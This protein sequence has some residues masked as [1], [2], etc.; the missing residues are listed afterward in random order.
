MPDPFWQQPFRMLQ[1]NLREIDAAG[2]DVAALLDVI[3]DY[4]GDAILANAGGIVAWYPTRLPFHRKNK[5]LDFDF[6]G[7]VIDEAHARGMKVMLRM[8]VSK[9]H[10]DQYEAHPDWFIHD[11]EGRPVREWS[12]LATC[13]NGP[14]WQKHNFELVDELL[15]GYAPDALFYNHYRYGECWCDR[16]RDAFRRAAGRELPDREDWDDPGWRAYVRFRYQAVEEYSRRLVDFVQQR[17]PDTAVS[18]PIFVTLDE[19]ERLCRSG[20]SAQGMLVPDLLA[21]EAFN[22]LGRPFPQ[23]IYLG[24]EE[25]RISRS[26]GKPLF[27]GITY[28][29]VFASRRSGQPAAQ[30]AHDIIQVAAHGG[31]PALAVSGTF[32]QDDR[33]ALPAA[34]EAYRFL[35]ANHAC[36]EEMRPLGRTLLVYSQKTMDFYGRGQSRERAL[37]EYRGFYEALVHHHLLFDVAHDGT[38]ASMDLARYRTILLPNVACLSADEASLLDQFVADG[39]NLIAS[40]E[41]GMYDDEGQQTGRFALASLRLR[42][43]E[44]RDLVGSYLLVGNEKGLLRSFADV[45]LIALNGPFLAVEPDRPAGGAAP[46]SSHDT[47]RAE[48][49]AGVRL[50]ERRR[51]RLWPLRDALRPRDRDLPSL[52]AWA[53][54]TTSRACPSRRCCSPTCWTARTAPA[55]S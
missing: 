14:Y 22:A 19:P 6:V 3:R 5:H 21:T 30:L 33:K 39:G 27:V 51:G 2:L 54:P 37:F 52:A 16:C 7:Q 41:T 32:E 4:G 29:E 25:S 35:A 10:D 20:W 34:R 13:F 55:R 50:L 44:R 8:D 47:R 46:R 12:M 49:H 43:R 1:P 17:R 53:G 26:M 48:Q 42:V 31:N 23:W 9:Q 15:A 40:Y 36:Y 38:L 11:R 18:L 45:D 28:S 24:G